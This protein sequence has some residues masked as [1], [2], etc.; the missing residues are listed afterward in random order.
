MTRHLPA[1]TLVAALAGCASGPPLVTT[2]S[3]ARAALGQL[4]RVTGTAVREKLGDSVDGAGVQVVC[5]DS[6]FPDDRIG[7]TV[8]VEGHLEMTQEFSAVVGPGGEI[9]QGTAPGTSLLVI[10][11]CA[12]R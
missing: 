12:L 6:R 4:V 3:E 10:R 5:V 9:G 8:T 11:D 1:I 2:V 7:G